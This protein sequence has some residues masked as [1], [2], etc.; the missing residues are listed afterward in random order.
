MNKSSDLDLD[1]SE[2]VGQVVMPRLDFKDPNSLETA[3][4][5]V[6]NYK[7]G[8]FIIFNGEIEEVRRTT[9]ELQSMSRVPLFFGCDAERGFRQIVSG[10][11]RFPF[12]MSQGAISEPVLVQK[13]ALQTTNEM[14]YCGLNLLFAPVL[15]V[16][17]NPN[18]P[19]INIRAF[20]DDV[21]LVAKLGKVFIESAQKNGVLACAKHFPGHGDCDVDSHVEL[22]A[23]Y[24]N[25]NELES[26]ELFPFIKAINSGVSSVMLAHISFPKID[27]S[28]SPVT[29]SK[30][31]IDDVL[32]SRLGYDGL[33]ITDSF[34]MDA[35]KKFGKEKAYASKSIY[36]GSDIILDPIDPTL[37]ID[38]LIVTAEDDEGFLSKLKKSVGRILR[39]KENVDQNYDIYKVEP[40]FELVQEICDR[41]VCVI[42]KGE[43]D[44]NR[45]SINVF[46]VTNSGDNIA[47]PFINFLEDNDIIVE[48][49][50]Y[51]Y[52]DKEFDYSN[53]NKDVTVLNLVFTS[54][55]AWNLYT[56]LPKEFID[57]FK[58][59][60]TKNT[61]SVLIC[62]GSPYVL[63]LLPRFDEI[64]CLFDSIEPCQL[65]AAKA[66]LNKVGIQS[67]L[68]VRF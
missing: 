31:F 40:N 46:D 32:R 25:Y 61:K 3:F 43:L 67:R 19:I 41:S 13:Q 52:P 49:T 18:N 66:L 29:F 58:K 65:A 24:K 9:T 16:N 34:R 53:T 42:R 1:I 35:L 63:K 38:E 22:P 23:I 12:L 45:C 28:D 7:V 6:R 50:S 14:K 30:K 2:I 20:S 5:L 36:A 21:A 68:T 60:E 26:L 37:L 59:L 15:D 10:A 39:Y 27:E 48:S 56:V 47:S 51:F 4:K 54:V 62:F 33:V 64:L 17:T 55:S 44:F 11:T 8:G 57:Y